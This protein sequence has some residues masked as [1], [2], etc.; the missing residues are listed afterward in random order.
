MGISMSSSNG[1]ATH[2][3]KDNHINQFNEE[4]IYFK[5][6]NCVELTFISKEEYDS[7]PRNSQ[8]Y[9]YSYV[10]P[11]HYIIQIWERD[12]DTYEPTIL[13]TSEPINHRNI[14][15]RYAELV[16]YI[17]NN[18]DCNMDTRIYFSMTEC[19]EMQD[20]VIND[21][22]FNDDD[23]QNIKNFLQL[24]GINNYNRSSEYNISA[25]SYHF[26]KYYRD[27]ELNGEIDED[28]EDDY[29]HEFQF[30]E[31]VQE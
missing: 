1:N 10:V 9:M 11:D 28:S 13:T 26:F 16:T 30:E 6:K 8:E 15:S 21:D 23:H 2:P 27:R 3:V 25:Y 24:F 22:D 29:E 14:Q 18:I 31:V 12:G 19:L 17:I 20:I 4:I 7:A 5:Y